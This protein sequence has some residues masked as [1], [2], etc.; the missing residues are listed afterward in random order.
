M[1]FSVVDDMVQIDDWESFN[2]GRALVREEGLFCGGSSGSIVAAA[3]EI[4]KNIGP[5]KTI[6]VTLCD[7]GTRYTSKYLSDKWMEEKGFF[8][9]RTLLGPIADLISRR[10]SLTAHDDASNDDIQRM[11]TEG[12]LDY[13]P[14]QNV[15][16]FTAIATRTGQRLSIGGILFSEARIE[17]MP[18]ILAK[19]DAALVM[20]HDGVVGVVTKKEYNARIGG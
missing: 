10:S 12:D 4:A 14:L 6:V 13:L 8:N 17:E 11:M 16:D 2:I 3:I 20:T 5:D 1:D 18:H 15:D 7:S 9:P 19:G